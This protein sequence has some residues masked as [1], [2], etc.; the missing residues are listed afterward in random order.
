MSVFTYNH[1]WLFALYFQIIKKISVKIIVLNNDNDCVLLKTDFSSKKP[2]LENHLLLT[3]QLLVYKKVVFQSRVYLT[4]L[5][6]K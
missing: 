3:W 1:E 5:S 4:A 6:L 2:V